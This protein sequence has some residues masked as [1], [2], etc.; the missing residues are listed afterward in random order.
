MCLLFLAQIQKKK[1]LVSILSM[2]FSYYSLYG[3]K[4]EKHRILTLFVSVGLSASVTTAPGRSFRKLI[5]FR[6]E[7]NEIELN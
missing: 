3:G 1:Q 5:F 4:F 6:K 7:K 2:Q